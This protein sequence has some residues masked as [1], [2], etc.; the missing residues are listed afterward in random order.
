MVQFSRRT[1]LSTQKVS[2]S[3]EIFEMNIKLLIFRNKMLAEQFLSKSTII[4]QSISWDL[5]YQDQVY[6]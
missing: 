2:F 1:F 6:Q 4:F 3:I 5:A